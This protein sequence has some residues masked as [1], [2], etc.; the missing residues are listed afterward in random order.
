MITRIF[1]TLFISTSFL[2]AQATD[3]PTAIPA[4]E[5]VE[6]LYKG[7]KF[8]P[9]QQLAFAELEYL[10][11]QKIKELI[12]LAKLEANEK[13]HKRLSTIYN[14]LYGKNHK[15][16]TASSAGLEMGWYLVMIGDK[17]STLPMV[18]KVQPN[19]AA[20]QAG[21]IPGDVINK[22]SRFPMRGSETRNQFV[23]LINNWPNSKPLDLK[24]SRSNSKDPANHL[25]KNKKVNLTLFAA[26]KDK[27]NK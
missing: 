6:M 7:E 3:T 17:V 21:L 2:A 8:S 4:E 23:Q 15:M 19:S 11:P 13:R 16:P 9:E 25:D 5:F 26:K 27:P 20:S 18:L 14:E 12:V 10:E 22:V 24:I 1:A